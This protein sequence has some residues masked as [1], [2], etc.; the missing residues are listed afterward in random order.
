MGICQDDEKFLCPIK[1]IFFTCLCVLFSKFLYIGS[2]FCHIYGFFGNS[3]QCIDNSSEI[4]YNVYRHTKVGGDERG[5]CEICGGYFC[6]SE[7]PMFVGFYVG[8]GRVTG[9]CGRCGRLIYPSDEYIRK[10]EILL[11]GDCAEI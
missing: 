4:R 7:C 11:C 3:C 6:T 9:G 8:K 10:G 2:L 5:M 1:R